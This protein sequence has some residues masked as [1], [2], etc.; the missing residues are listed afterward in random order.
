MG[1]DSFA[2]RRAVLEAVAGAG[3]DQ[4]DAVMS[5]Q[6]VDQEVAV[7][8]VLILADPGVDQRGVGQAREARGQVAASAGDAVG[9]DLTALGVRIDDGA[10]GVEAQ[11]EALTLQIRH[12]IDEVAV[13]E[14]SPDRQRWWREAGVSRTDAE[15]IDLLAG[16][17]DA[18]RKQRGEQGRKPGTAGID[19]AV[20]PH[21]GSNLIDAAHRLGRTRLKGDG[22][23]HRIA[24]DGLDAASRDQ[25]AG[26]FLQEPGLPSTEDD[27][28]IGGA[29]P[30]QVEPAMRLAV[31]RQPSQALAHVI[32]AG[33][34]EP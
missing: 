4:P 17:H 5:R 28:R 11:F 25:R 7:G 27:L 31:L 22:G 30:R 9:A 32:I 8:A 20:S 18:A 24:H 16:R 12:A 14:V 23:D 15:M 2:N 6:A 21:A 26:A 33:R 1:G 10:V 34:R 13:V 3:A 19:E 29:E